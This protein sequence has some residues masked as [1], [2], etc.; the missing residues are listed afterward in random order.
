MNHLTI[1]YLA[2]P[3]RTFNQLNGITRNP[4]MELISIYNE[5][6]IV[7]GCLKMTPTKDEHLGGM[8]HNAYKAKTGYHLKSNS[9][10]FNMTELPF[11]TYVSFL[12]ETD[13]EMILPTFPELKTYAGFTDHVKDVLNHIPIKE[14]KEFLIHTLY[15]LLND[16]LSTDKLYNT[17]TKHH[18][19]IDDLSRIYNHMLIIGV[20]CANGT[21]RS[22]LEAML[23]QIKLNERIESLR[24]IKI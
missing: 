8:I 14:V 18:V 10:N 24:A 6:D 3:E 19:E 21:I 2:L 12:T 17:L 22:F 1:F 11:Q 7:L 20:L 23:D 9:F 5:G 4:Q 13:V 15:Q 16:S